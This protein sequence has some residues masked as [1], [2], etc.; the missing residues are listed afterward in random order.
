MKIL[1]VCAGRKDGNSSEMVNHAIRTANV[2]ADIEVMHLGSKNILFCDGCLTCDETGKC[3]INDD[4]TPI[5]SQ[6]DNYEAFV[7]ATPARWSLLSGD[8]K[9]FIDRLNPLAAN[10]K[11]DGKKAIVFAV[12]QS[13]KD[14]SE[15]I[16]LAAESV[17]H[18]CDNANIEV[19][20][21]V[22]AVN[23]LQPRDVCLYT[24]ALKK[25]HKALTALNQSIKKG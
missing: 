2:A 6:I 4:M 24:D 11:L 1:A 18:F 7:F 13:E 3:H 9:T 17:K 10:Q 14:D 21:C 12:G 19:V 15:S 20:D 23:C 8:M 16:Q 25:C 22:I 5:I